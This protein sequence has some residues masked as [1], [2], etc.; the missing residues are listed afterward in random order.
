MTRRQTML[1]KI[2]SSQKD[3]DE[4][5]EPS[6][7]LS[8]DIEGLDNVVVSSRLSTYTRFDRLLK[9]V[10]EE[11]AYTS[12]P[13]PQRVIKEE[14]PEELKSAPSTWTLDSYGNFKFYERWHLL[15]KERVWDETT[16]CYKYVEHEDPMTATV[17]KHSRVDWRWWSHYVAK[18]R[19]VKL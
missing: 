14:T 8:A 16:H 6:P 13:S 12:N 9:M 1:S 19:E 17:Q 7:H 3:D 18:A 15:E 2:K 10:G 5:R 11:P 4:F